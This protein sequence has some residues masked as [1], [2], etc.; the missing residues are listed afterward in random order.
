MA[1]GQDWKPSTLDPGFHTMLGLKVIHPPINLLRPFADEKTGPEQE[2]DPKVLQDP[3]E[4]PIIL[5]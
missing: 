1:P 5:P 3:T 2:R 4:I